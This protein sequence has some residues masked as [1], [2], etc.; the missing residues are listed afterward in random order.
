MNYISCPLLN[1]V[2]SE[3]SVRATYIAFMNE[4]INRI[5]FVCDRIYSYMDQDYLP[6]TRT[7]SRHFVAKQYRTLFKD[8]KQKDPE[9]YENFTTELCNGWSAHVSNTARGYA[10]TYLKRVEEAIN[11]PIIAVL[12]SDGGKNTY[13]S[14]AHLN[15]NETEYNLLLSLSSK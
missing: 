13:S 1:I 12:E 11:I 5:P 4:L 2:V 15:I 3:K 10:N 14:G 9:S 7:V 8:S 6:G